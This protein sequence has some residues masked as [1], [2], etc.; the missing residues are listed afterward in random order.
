[1]EKP[2]KCPRCGGSPLWRKLVSETE[3]SKTYSVH[4]RD[5]DYWWK[6]RYETYLSS[7][8]PEKDQLRACPNCGYNQN[9][10]VCR[11]VQLAADRVRIHLECTQC[12]NTWEDTFK[13]E[14]V[15]DAGA[16]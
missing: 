1:M 12:H 6:E 13:I 10:R 16:S 11:L 3:E 4:C 14:R 5:C 7:I 9:P 8:E 15:K 2:T